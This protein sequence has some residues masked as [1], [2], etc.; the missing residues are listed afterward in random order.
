M[1]RIILALTVAAVLTAG[2]SSNGAD[3]AEAREKA[4]ELHAEAE[5]AELPVSDVDILAH[6]HGTDGGALCENAGEDITKAINTFS[7]QNP[8]L[9]RAGLLDEQTFEKDRLVIE[10]YCPD[11]LEAFDEYVAGLDLEEGSN[12]A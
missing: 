3:T 10:V 6:I 5:A 7:W 9:M 12:S 2:C 4:E 1:K 8:S 11:R